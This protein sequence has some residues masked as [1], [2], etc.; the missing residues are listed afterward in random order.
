MDRY[1]A[2]RYAAETF[3]NGVDDDYMAVVKIRHD[4]AWLPECDAWGNKQSEND[5]AC[6]ETSTKIDTGVYGDVR[7]FKNMTLEETWVE[8]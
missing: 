7:Y 1:D 2:R 3:Y 8:E 4:C 6:I 5:W